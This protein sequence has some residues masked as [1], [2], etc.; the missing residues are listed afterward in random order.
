[1]SVT[2]FDFNGEKVHVATIPSLQI[3]V[4]VILW[5]GRYFRLDNGRYIES[6]AIVV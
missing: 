5:A 2:L 6:T 1:M 4:G 3:G